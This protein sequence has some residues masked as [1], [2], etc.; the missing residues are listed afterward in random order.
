MRRY[1]L[2]EDDV[3]AVLGLFWMFASLADDPV[4]VEA[5]TGD[6][7]DDL[8]LT[9]CAEKRCDYLVTGDRVLLDLGQHA[10]TVILT[11]RAFREQLSERSR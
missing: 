11:P 1:G 6:P 9:V 5:L 10:S 2:G 8:L 7:A 3:R 4:D